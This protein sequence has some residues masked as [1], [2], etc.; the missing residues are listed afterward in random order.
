M[1]RIVRQFWWKSLL[2]LVPSL[3]ILAVLPDKEEL[4]NSARFSVGIWVVV[5]C[6][7]LPVSDSH[8]KRLFNQVFDWMMSR[9]L[10]GRT[11]ERAVTYMLWIMFISMIFT[12]L[13]FAFLVTSE[14]GQLL[15]LVGLLAILFYPVI[16][17][18]HQMIHG[19]QH[20]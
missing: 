4:P 14:V 7:A 8:Y 3:L 20:A 13:L 11:K 17:L 6:I 16:S 15:F 1:R 19:G 12:F 18:V 10:P 2:L 5:L 9:L